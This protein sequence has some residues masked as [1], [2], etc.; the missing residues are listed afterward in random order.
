MTGPDDYT[1]LKLTQ[2]WVLIGGA[3]YREA[4]IRD[5]RGVRFVA[6]PDELL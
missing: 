1:I 4:W 5:D 2:R 3:W 6:I